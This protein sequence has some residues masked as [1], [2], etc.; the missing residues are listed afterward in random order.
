MPS[1]SAYLGGFGVLDVNFWTSEPLLEFGE[2]LDKSGLVYT[3]RLSDQVFFV[4]ATSVF[5]P[6]AALH[7]Y[8]KLGP[9]RHRFYERIWGRREVS[10]P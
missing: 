5:A 4:L 1:S 8:A 3:K 2:V 10:E 9:F 6:P 7:Q